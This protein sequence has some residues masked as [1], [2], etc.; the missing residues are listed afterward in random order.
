MAE[1]KCPGLPAF[2]LNA[3]L[4]A[5]GATVLVPRIRLRWTGDRTPVAVLSSEDGDPVELLAS[6]WPD[7]GVS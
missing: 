1:V 4:A 7:G 2:W 3:W 5:V 6:S